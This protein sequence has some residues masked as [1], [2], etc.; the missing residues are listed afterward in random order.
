[1]AACQHLEKAT[2]C[3]FV[4]I[5]MLLI[6]ILYLFMN[7]LDSLGFDLKVPNVGCKPTVDLYSDV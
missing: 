5:S 7:S 1:M 2:E 3:C 4:S 6:H